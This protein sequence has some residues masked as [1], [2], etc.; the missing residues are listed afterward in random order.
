MKQEHTSVPDF[1]APF[2]WSY[3]VAKMDINKDKTV[4]ITNVLNLGT[5]QATDWLCHV[6]SVDTLRSVVAY[7]APGQWNKRSLNYW[8]IV[9]D[10]EPVVTNRFS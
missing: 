6:Y 10:V 5:R 9:F 3:D 4:I 2:L 8:S 1:V 7:P